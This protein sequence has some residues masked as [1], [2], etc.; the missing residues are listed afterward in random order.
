MATRLPDRSAY[1]ETKNPQLW[2]QAKLLFSQ[3]KSLTSIASITGLGRD[4][5]SSQLARLGIRKRR[6]NPQRHKVILSPPQ[7]HEIATSY[8]S[9]E[10][11]MSIAKRFGITNRRVSGIL[12][13]AC[14]SVRGYTSR[15]AKLPFGNVFANP[16]TSE[17]AAYWI[18]FLL[19]DGCMRERSRGHSYDCSVGLSANDI[20]HLEKLRSFTGLN[21]KI[22]CRRTK[23]N[24]YKDGAMIA[25]YR[26][27][28]PDIIATLI[29]YGI[30]PR[31]SK[32]AI[33]DGRLKDNRHFWRGV[34]DG[35][36]SILNKKHTYAI[37]LVG[38]NET[39]TD[40]CRW[41]GV[42]VGYE[43]MVAKH[44]TIFKCRIS[45]PFA[46]RVIELLYSDALVFLDRK[47]EIAENAIEALRQ[48]RLRGVED[49]RDQSI[50]DRIGQS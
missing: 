48:W 50:L 5:I 43:P 39:V 27:T 9:G 38:S 23:A 25:E 32:T 7:L 14:V 16:E 3:G 8:Q 46:L 15:N 37:Q 19:A 28:H 30:R 24:S 35:D 12:E 21:N 29:D 33:A 20:S 42:L 6:A 41:I 47:K 44:S 45:G 34:I 22:R 4:V 49:N 2:E 40:F 36:G 1:R 31:K 10:T 17:E 13:N 26:F 11:A 18:G